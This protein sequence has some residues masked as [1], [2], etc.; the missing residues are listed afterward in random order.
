MAIFK[1]CDG[2]TRRDFLRAGVFRH[3]RTDSGQLLSGWQPPV[4]SIR[5]PKAKLPS[6][7]I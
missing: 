4:T 6:L 5:T 1:N 2:T 3:H 7:S